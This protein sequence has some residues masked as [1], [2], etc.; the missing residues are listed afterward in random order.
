MPEADNA[1]LTSFIIASTNWFV[2]S[3]FVLQKLLFHLPVRACLP[4]A[5]IIR[6]GRVGRFSSGI[7]C[8]FAGCYTWWTVIAS[9]NIM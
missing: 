6:I 7:I 4:T 2:G 3:E 8:F 9:A 5:S 1:S